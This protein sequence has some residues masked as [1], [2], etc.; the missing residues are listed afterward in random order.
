[1]ATAREPVAA[2]LCPKATASSVPANEYE[3]TATARAP[4][5]TAPVATA[6]PWSP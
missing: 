6:A 3:P 5:T 2:A 4:F 1:M